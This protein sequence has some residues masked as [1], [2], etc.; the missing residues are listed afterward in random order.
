MD[1]PIDSANRQQAISE[2]DGEGWT[3]LQRE[4]RSNPTP[5]GP[6]VRDPTRMWAIVP[7]SK[8]REDSVEFNAPA[9]VLKLPEAVTKLT[10]KI[11]SGLPRSS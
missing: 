6:T 11:V 1:Y 10:G 9:G 3:R 8:A 4:S 7:P 5:T 2:F